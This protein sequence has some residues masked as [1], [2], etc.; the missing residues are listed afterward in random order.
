MYK[1]ILFSFIIALIFIPSAALLAAQTKDDV[2]KQY[3]LMLKTAGLPVATASSEV[4]S[5]IKQMGAAQN[6]LD[7][8]YSALDKRV[9]A[10]R[11]TDPKKNPALALVKTAKSAVNAFKAMKPVEHILVFSSPAKGV[12][13]SVSPDS[14]FGSGRDAAEK[15]IADTSLYLI[16]PARPGSVP[17]GD[18]MTDFI[19]QL[20]RQ[21]FRFAYLAILVSLVVSGIMWITAMDNED[22]VTK[23]K[24]IIYYSLIGFAFVTLAF[25]IV[26]AITDIDFFRLL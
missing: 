8:S 19:P 9:Q 22:K 17:Q 21:L 24:H 1:R 13:P 6:D 16:S 15:A 26:R 7:N 20:I 14:D 23:A 11:S 18:I 12:A 2:V 5:L 3:E 4:D 10:L 25:A